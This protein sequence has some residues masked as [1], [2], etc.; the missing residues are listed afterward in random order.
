[1][2]RAVM[3]LVVVVVVPVSMLVIVGEKINKNL[4]T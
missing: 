1:M 3:S 2:G 4:H